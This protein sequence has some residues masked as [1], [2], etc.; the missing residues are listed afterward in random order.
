MHCSDIDGS[1]MA[2]EAC[3][4]KLEY[5]ATSAAQAEEL[6]RVSWTGARKQELKK[7]WTLS[8]LEQPHTPDHSLR[9]H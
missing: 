7:M 5:V 3:E 8:Q 1:Q 4:V 9:V 6:S 2:A